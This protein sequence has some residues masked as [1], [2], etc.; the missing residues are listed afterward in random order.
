MPSFANDTPVSGARLSSAG[1]GMQ[2]AIVQCDLA[3]ESLG[4]TACQV[5][6]AVYR[7]GNGWIAYHPIANTEGGESNWGEVIPFMKRI[8]RQ[9]PSLEEATSFVPDPAEAIVL[10]LKQ[11]VR[12]PGR[13]LK[14]LQLLICCMY[15]DIV[16]ARTLPL[17]GQTGNSL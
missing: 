9:I 14:I 17:N 11:V 7:T 5:S 8:A 4:G 1:A 16:F 6:L 12:L 15:V 3:G 2:A 10:P 13:L